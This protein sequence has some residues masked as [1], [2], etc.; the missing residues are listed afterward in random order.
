[1]YIIISALFKA[2][3]SYLYVQDASCYPLVKSSRKEYCFRVQAS[4]VSIE[5]INKTKVYEH[6]LF[7]LHKQMYA[8]NYKLT[9]DKLTDNNILIIN[10]KIHVHESMSGHL[11]FC[12]GDQN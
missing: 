4:L 10:K 12:Y 5:D 11:G 1:M 3:S 7:I 6:Y 9:N 2:A 8:K